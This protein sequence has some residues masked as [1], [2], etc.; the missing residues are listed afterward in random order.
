MAR[1]IQIIHDGILEEV[2]ESVTAGNMTGYH[3]NDFDLKRHWNDIC[4]TINNRDPF[5]ALKDWRKVFRLVLSQDNV[6]YIKI[7]DERFHDK[8]SPLIAP[9]TKHANLSCCISD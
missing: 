7:V 1:Y 3:R 2:F 6:I 4:I 9:A 8:S 5:Y